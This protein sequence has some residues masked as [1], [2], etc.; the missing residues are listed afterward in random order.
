M[1]ATLQK[2]VRATLLVV[3]A[4]AATTPAVAWVNPTAAAPGGTVPAMPL[5]TSSTAQTKTGYFNISLPSTSNNWGMQV[6]G[7]QYGGYFNGTYTGLQGIGGTG[8][9]VYG[10]SNS[11]QG[12][13]GQS[14][15]A[16]GVYGVSTNNWGGYFTGGYGVYGANS[17]GYYGML[18]YGSWSLYGNGNGYLSGYMQASNAYGGAYSISNTYGYC[19]NGNP[20]AGGGCGC[21]SYAPNSFSSGAGSEGG[22]LN[23]HYECY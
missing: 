12:V 5:N 19:W 11:S 6:S 10:Q 8:Y 14:T 18:A 20:L 21:P 23:V 22:D 2:I 3:L 9:G 15:S 13:Y 1:Y 17:S 4:T 7:G 16:Q